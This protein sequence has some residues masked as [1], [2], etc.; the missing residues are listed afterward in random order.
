[1]GAG[2]WLRPGPSFSPET[3]IPELGAPSTVRTQ[4]E[5]RSLT[6]RVESTWAVEEALPSLGCQT[7][8]P[9]LVDP[10]TQECAARADV[11]QSLR[12]SRDK[13]TSKRLRLRTGTNCRCW[14][15]SLLLQRRRR[16]G[17]Y[18]GNLVHPS[19]RLR[20]GKDNSNHFGS[21]SHGRH[22]PAG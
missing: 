8:R 20:A 6:R 22:R 18:C 10:Q 16:C 4:A 3:P 17:T 14:W 13:L 11:M 2:R 15:P 9:L 7:S 5:V 19:G 21:H 1:M 12:H